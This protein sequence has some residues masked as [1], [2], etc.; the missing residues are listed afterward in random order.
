MIESKQRVKV[1]T[2]ANVP[3]IMIVFEVAGLP[4][5]QERFDVMMQ[6]TRSPD[7]GLNV[8][9]GE[10]VPLLTPLTFH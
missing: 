6:D 9:I 2:E 3:L 7:A 4:E 10:F 5:T 1:T 8:Y